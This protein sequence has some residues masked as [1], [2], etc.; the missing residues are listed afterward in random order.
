M[1]TSCSAKEHLTDSRRGMVGLV[2]DTKISGQRSMS[3][4]HSDNTHRNCTNI[5]LAYKDMSG[6]VSV[7]IIGGQKVVLI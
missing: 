1:R 2:T 4:T 5:S 3:A 7:L 6:D